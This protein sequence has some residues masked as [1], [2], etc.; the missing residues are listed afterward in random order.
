M[1]MSSTNREVAAG[2]SYTHASSANGVHDAA[3]FHQV[4]LEQTY[5]LSKRTTI[6]FLEAYQHA[7]GQTLGASGAGSIV[8]SVAMVGRI[9]NSTPSSGKSQFV[10]VAGIR[11]SF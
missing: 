4:S 3:R 10:G 8:E 5:S 6:Y 11:H 9:S 1:R 2:Y 7:G